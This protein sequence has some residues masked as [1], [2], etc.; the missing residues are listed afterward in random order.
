MGAV[1]SR[2]QGAGRLLGRGRTAEVYAWGPGQVIKLYLDRF[3]ASW[4]E[5]E[6]SYTR[7]AHEA[8]LPVPAVLDVVKVDNRAG[9]V[10]ERVDGPSMLQ[11][12]GH[13]PWRLVPMARLLADLQ[14]RLHQ[15]SGD[16]LPSWHEALAEAIAEATLLS[17]IERAAALR[18]LEALPPGDRLCHGDLHPDNV[19]LTSRGPIIIDWLAARCGPPAADVA[20]TSLLLRISANPR[21]RPAR[22]LVQSLRWLFHA[23]YLNR[24]LMLYATT[25]P[26]TAEMK[27]RLREEINRW[28]LPMAAARLREEIP[29]ERPRLLRLIRRYVASAEARP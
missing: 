21:R 11:A 4:V 6:A 16:G 9:I 7:R 17:D 8:G 1:P 29:F 2:P 28:M 12:L 27:R 20:R 13:R 23:V 10:F 15:H 19:I 22:W 3:P 24:Y 14:S 25:T 26:S 5:R 18:R